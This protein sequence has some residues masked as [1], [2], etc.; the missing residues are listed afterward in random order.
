MKILLDTNIV[1]HR[2]AATVVDGDI[3]ILFR[4]L[5]NLHHTKCIHSVTV[6][7]LEKHEDAKVRESFK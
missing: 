3:G 5:D 7:E 2:E 4:W 1:I 6:E